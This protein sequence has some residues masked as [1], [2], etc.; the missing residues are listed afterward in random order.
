[1][2]LSQQLRE[3]LDPQTF[4]LV[5]E[6]SRVRGETG[7]PVYL[8]GGVVRDLLLRQPSFDLDFVVEGDPLLLAQTFARRL[9]GRVKPHQPFGTVSVF[10]PEGRR[11]DFAQ[12][13]RETYPHWGALPMVEPSSLFEDLRRRDFTINA[14]AI[15]LSQEAFGE[16]IDPFGGVQDLEAQILRVLHHCSF[17]DDPTRILRG[18]R[19]AVR[20][21]FWFDP[22]TEEL[23]RKALSKDCFSWVSAD[24]FRQDFFKGL[25]ENPVLFLQK[26]ASLGGLAHFDPSLSVDW[27]LLTRISQTI[28]EWRNFQPPV[29][30]EK[31]R[32]AYLAGLFYSLGGL[33]ARELCRSKLNLSPR[34]CRVVTLAIEEANPLTLQ[35]PILSNAQLRQCLDR[36]ALESL[37][38]LYSWTLDP[39]VR[40][41]VKEY[42]LRLRSIRLSITGDDLIG[43]GFEPGPLFG[44]ALR[45]TLAEK[46]EGRLSSYEEEKAFAVGRLSELIQRQKELSSESLKKDSR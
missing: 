27:D 29:S 17:W 40:E 8:V 23:A 21:N 4:R 31:P 32:L 18:L 22:Y 3:A 9:G 10:L 12:A 7:I 20:L 26:L 37:V 14:L 36:W 30:V 34:D 11:V 28:Q 15:D 2:N 44:Q 19:Y 39:R 41:R 46:L 24:R 45:E 25:E 6:V 42:L 13:R 5:L 16:V 43:M 33:K 1:M 35:I 38:F